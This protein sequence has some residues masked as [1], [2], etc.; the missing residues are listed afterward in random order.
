MSLASICCE[1]R[2]GDEPAIAVEKDKDMGAE[3]F[4]SLQSIST[5]ETFAAFGLRADS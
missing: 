1:R 2:S 3:V 4:A 5:L